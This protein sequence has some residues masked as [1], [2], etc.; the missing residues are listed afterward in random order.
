[1]TAL[2]AIAL[3]VEPPAPPAPPPVGAG[4]SHFLSLVQN[5]QGQ[6]ASG[7]ASAP[8]AASAAASAAAA[9]PPKPMTASSSGGANQGKSGGSSAG[10]ASNNASNSV[11]SGMTAV[12][13]PMAVPLVMTQPTAT[14]GGTSAAPSSPATGTA[15]ASALSAA[16]AAA[17][18]A[19]GAT[20]TAATALNSG[21]GNTL[22]AAT[23]AAAV[24]PATMLPA[25]MG[26]VSAA[27]AQ[28][29]SAFV[30][31]AG[32]GKSGTAPTPTQS[33]G[34]ASSTGNAP[35][36]SAPANAATPTLPSMAGNLSMRV[37]A[38]AV[39]FVSQP[40]AAMASFTPGTETAQGKADT[41]ASESASPTP[42]ASHAA[43]S[44]ADASDNQQAGQTTQ[45][46]AGADKNGAAPLP[47]ATAANDSDKTAGTT[48]AP[49]TDPGSAANGAA[50]LQS[51]AQTTGSPAS[52]TP[53][54][55]PAANLAMLPQA[56]S[57]QVALTLRQA[58]NT[59]NDHIQIQLQPADLGAV[60]VKL[61]INHDGRVTMVVSADRSDTLN[62]LKQDAPNLTQALR[63]AGLQA[64]SG[65]LSF[66]LRGG[67]QFNQ[68]QQ[69]PSYGSAAPT[70][71][72]TA[73]TAD[74][75]TSA[76]AVARTVGSHNGSLD[77]HV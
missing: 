32:Q 34:T 51:M 49:S 10:S 44:T 13:I 19:N 28:N 2:P 18:A 70:N 67:Y 8:G 37:A 73:G 45:I 66:N 17:S 56:A 75:L 22:P 58:V 55:T 71:A 3:P 23:P 69:Q 74:D 64:D 47:T 14:P 24:S 43:T 68:Q 76:V 52:A 36:T 53:P 40:R 60:D 39:M 35:T 59:G 7:A 21:A 31:P 50:A 9:P 15:A 27:A 20:L 57:A 11:G 25:A 16:Q 29:F 6:P 46:V 33:A 4:G 12:V 38:N 61:N 1:M 41:T 26:P 30:A 65:S 63:D 54:A 72:Y 42:D 48:A 5:A 62:M 77:I